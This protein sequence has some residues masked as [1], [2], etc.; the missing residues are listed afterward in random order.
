M[1][2][3]QHLEKLLNGVADATHQLITN[4]NRVEAIN[5]AVAIL[6]E[7]AS[8][9]SVYLFENSS[10]SGEDIPRASLRFEWTSESSPANIENPDLQERP[11]PRALYRQL[12][13][14]QTINSLVKQ[15]PA[16]LT[17]IFSN[18]ELKSVL[19]IPLITQNT[20]WGFIGFASIHK[21]RV[22]SEG[23]EQALKTIASSLVATYRNERTQ[24][25][26]RESEN[27]YRSVFQKNPAV[28]ILLDPTDGHII[29]ANEAACEFY[30]YT[31]QQLRE[32]TIYQLN[33][34]SNEDLQEFM[35]LALTEKQNHF[36]ARHKLADGE[37]REVEVFTGP[38]VIDETPFL[39]S[40]I[41]DITDRKRAEQ[42]LE[43][44]EKFFKQFVTHT[45]AAVAVFDKELHY[46]YY[47]K[48][49]LKIFELED[50]DDIT[51]QHHLEVEPDLPERWQEANKKSLSG[52]VQRCEEDYFIKPDGSTEWL[53]WES[54]PWYDEFG[55]VGGIIIFVERITEKR[56][57]AEVEAN[58]RNHKL[59]IAAKVEAIEEERKHIARELHDGLGQLI[60]AAHFNLELLEDNHGDT[61]DIKRYTSGIKKILDETIEEV[62]NIS[63]NLRPSILDDLGLVPALRNLVD[64]Y[65]K[66]SEL[67]IK[68]DVYE[69]DQR[70][71]S[72]LETTIYRVVQ[73]GINNI[74]KHSR[75]TE[76]TIQIY[77]RDNTLLLLISDNG[78]GI[79]ID[80][81]D[82]RGNSDALGNGLLNMKERVDMHNGLFQIESQPESGTEI[83]IELPL[84][85][86]EFT[87]Q[88]Q[89]TSY[90]QN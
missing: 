62:R 1:T 12:S 11:Y 24:K 72:R 34:S 9:D 59:R 5:S 49:W 55:K 82:L 21:E 53:R 40:I 36:T 69:L 64:N 44:G 2:Q 57:A 13:R 54:Y 8:V 45:P 31:K 80:L 79:D 38:V 67:A 84:E 81:D 48:R 27:R 74:V 17:S 83:I 47:S 51:G 33:A 70:I 15:M 35:H 58:Y 41:H 19:I 25:A 88:A 10:R 86:P 16:E 22:F 32:Q 43:A 63:Q 37:T 6:G 28:K 68:F 90:G 56:H 60:T 76:A 87:N 52:S 77:R 89:P 30:G 61:E 3:P 71:P 50:K 7:A 23:E 4:P 85:A 20:F 65:N 73:E 46:M 18:Y 14:G 66:G 75:A 78:I 42:R 26:Y 29:D 39:Y